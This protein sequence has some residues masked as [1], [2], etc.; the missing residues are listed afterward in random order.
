[1]GA[2]GIEEEAKGEGEETPIHWT[3]DIAGIRE[4]LRYTFN[5]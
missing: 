2:T 3:L 4:K 1:V 5:K